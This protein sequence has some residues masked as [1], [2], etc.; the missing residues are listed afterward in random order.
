MRNQTKN[1]YSLSEPAQRKKDST[2]SVRKYISS[3]RDEI[4]RNQTKKSK[5]WPSNGISFTPQIKKK[6]L[7]NPDLVFI[8]VL[9]K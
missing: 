2:T 6:A 7:V 8:S 9:L 3:K 1:I 4:K 5:E